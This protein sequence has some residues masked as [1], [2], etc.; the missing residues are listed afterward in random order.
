MGTKMIAAG[1]AFLA[2]AACA[3]P[4]FSEEPVALRIG[5]VQVGHVT[6]MY[7]IL[8]KEHPELFPHYGKSYTF[9]GVRFNGTTPEIQALAVNELEIASMASS[10]M[11]LG[12]TNAKLDLRMVSDL[13]QDGRPGS[14]DEPFVVKKDGPIK[15]IEDI[16]GKRIATNAIGSASD[17]SMRIMLRKHN[18]ADSD[19]TTIEANFANMFPMIE[20][21][22]VDLIPV[23]PQDMKRVFETGRYRTL[24][25]AGE[26]R[27]PA[28]TVAWAMRASFIAAHRAA[29]VD[30][31]EDHLR[32][33]HW[34]L[35]PAHHDAAVAIA[36]QVTKQK[37]D[38]LQYF[39]THDDFYRDPDG[40]PDLKAAQ[41]E[42]DDSAKLGILKEG[43]ELSPAYVDLSLIKEAKAR[44]N[45]ANGGG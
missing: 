26:A 24:Y 40:V 12:V 13:I 4:A 41:K 44:L 28:E 8:V 31:F 25:T 9:A 7:D 36:A 22:K 39:F 19:F 43:I 30:F 27:G 5:W 23:L 34:F 2:S 45:G 16:K 18:I 10:S 3:V 11:T 17:T 35:E 14:Y 21:D 37:P 1:L 6:P 15:T 33:L 42:I 20:Q 38:E 29:L 32:A